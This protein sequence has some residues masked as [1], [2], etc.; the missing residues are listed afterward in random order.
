MTA[1]LIVLGA[2]PAG[3]ACACTAAELGCT[4]LVLDENECAGGQVYRRAAPD[5]LTAGSGSPDAPEGQRLRDTLARSSATLVPQARV[6]SVLP[7]EDGFRVDAQTS[8]GPLSARARALLVATGAL[9]RVVPFSGWTTPG[10][11]GLAAAT[12]LLKAQRTAPGERVLVAGAGPLL[13]AVSAA[14]TATGA[15]VVATVDRNSPAAWFAALPR[16]RARPVLLAQG[17]GWLARIGRARTPLRFRSSVMAVEGTDRVRAATIA[18]L[19]PE[20]VARAASERFEVDSVVV[21]HGLT[22]GTE[23]TRLLRAEHVFDRALGGWRPVTDAGGRTSVRGLYAAGDGAGVL[24]AA[25]A[26]SGGAVAAFQIAGDLGLGI[27]SPRQL[28]ALQRQHRRAARFGA[29]MSALTALAPAHVDAMPA[30]TIACRCEDVTKAEIVEACAAGAADI[31]QLKH[32]TRCGMGPCQ[33][34]SCSEVV[35]EIVAGCLCAREPGLAR[36]AARARV[37]QWT[38]RVPLRPMPLAG[39]LG[40]FDYSDI[41]VPEPAPL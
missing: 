7:D 28:R 41:P 29:A 31:N 13:A 40:E 23:V 34:R 19:G 2:G 8:R 36:D 24:G 27:G 14:V 38:G 33:G 32:F 25:A 21:G 30:D 9:E 26:A 5:L 17:L 22:P 16:M 15:T 12:T 39:L 3:A 20:G 18:P 1:D 6:W 37:G 4:V 11:I 10:V 35:A